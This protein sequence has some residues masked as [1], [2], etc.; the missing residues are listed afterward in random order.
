MQS[1]IEQMERNLGFVE[2]SLTPL[3]HQFQLDIDM[4]NIVIN[5]MERRTQANSR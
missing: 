1:L 5:Q 4:W 3:K 2:G